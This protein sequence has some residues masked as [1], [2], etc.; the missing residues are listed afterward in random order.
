MNFNLIPQEQLDL[1]NE[2]LHQIKQILL[3]NRQNSSPN[4]LMTNKEAVAY[5]KVTSRT[6]QKYRDTGQIEF[7]QIGR[8]IF[9]RKEFLD[10]FILGKSRVGMLNIKGGI[11]EN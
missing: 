3:N 9:Y 10:E 5:L 1:L 11:Y 8:K 4:S 6:L 7:S 2:Q